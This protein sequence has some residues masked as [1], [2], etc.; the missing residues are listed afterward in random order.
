MMH[1]RDQWF[2][3]YAYTPGVSG[4]EVK[5]DPKTKQP[6]VVLGEDGKPHAVWHT[7]PAWGPVSD[8]EHVHH[9]DFYHPDPRV[10][11][12]HHQTMLKT[13][14]AV[15][16]CGHE[17]DPRTRIV[18]T[19]GNPVKPCPGCR[20]VTKAAVTEHN[21]ATENLRAKARAKLEAQL[22]EAKAQLAKVRS[23]KV[24]SAST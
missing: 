19:A 16:A 11:I 13:G 2:R 17:H 1:P 9:P 21:V 6:V 20:K 3:I 14:V 8:I 7:P 23:A 5:V 24:G 15:A 12:K 18:E 10:R 4:P 22:A